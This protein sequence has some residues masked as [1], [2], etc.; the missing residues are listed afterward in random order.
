M[1]ADQ[2]TPPSPARRAVVDRAAA[3]GDR[4]RGVGDRFRARG[5]QSAAPRGADSR[6]GRWSTSLL[7]EF[8]IAGGTAANSETVQ[9]TLFNPTRRPGADAA[10]RFGETADAARPVRAHRHDGDRRQEHG[11]PA[12]DRGRQVA[13]RAAGGHGQRHSGRRREARSRAPG[14][15][16]RNRRARCCA[17]RPIRGRP[18]S[19]RRRRHRP[20][21]PTPRP[22]RGP[23]GRSRR[24][25]AA[26]AA[27]GNADA[28]LAE[29]RRAARAAQAAAQ[30]QT[31]T[32]DGNPA[33]AA[34]PHGPGAHGGSCARRH[35]RPATLPIPDGP[36]CIAPISNPEPRTCRDDGIRLSRQPDNNNDHADPL[37]RGALV[38]AL[39][40]VLV[41]CA[42]QPR[43][44]CR[45]AAG[46]DAHEADERHAI[47]VAGACGRRGARAAAR[48]A[49]GRGQGADLQGHRRAR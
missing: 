33:P 34:R 7:P 26:A 49:D 1:A 12:R 25:S 23:A 8:A 9:R 4:A 36:T 22:G 14:A 42:S 3:G 19:L 31:S 48:A 11:V 27:A 46:G 16:R 28:S 13:S 40:L 47:D 45:S 44:G 24:C 37:F 35:P 20:R 21:V 15:R 6:P 43:A 2:R 18:C 5:A 38:C 32:P 39:P 10:G 29:R 41:A 17:W 30:A